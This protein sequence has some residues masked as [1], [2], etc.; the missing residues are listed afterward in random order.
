MTIVSVPTLTLPPPHAS[1]SSPALTALT[2]N[3]SGDKVGAVFGIRKTGNIRRIG[4]RFGTVTTPTDLDV[5][6][7]TISG[8]VPSGTLWG[9]NTN[10]TIASGSMASSTMVFAT[11][12]AD[13][14]VTKGQYIAISCVGSGSPNYQVSRASASVFI[15]QS[16]YLC[17]GTSGT[18][19]IANGKPLFAVE[20]DDGSYA[21]IIW[22]EPVSAINTHTYNTGSTPDE[23]A[24][25]FKIP[26][27][28][29]LSGMWV[30]L[31]LDNAADIVLYDSDGSTTLA[32]TSLT[33][34][35]RQSTTG[36]IPYFV[37]FSSSVTLTADT[38][39]YLSVK[40]TSGSSISIYS[41][42]VPSN[43]ALDQICSKNAYY[44]ARSDAGA[45]SDTDTR[46]PVMG[47]VIDGIDDGAGGSGGGGGHII[48]GG[49]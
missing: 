21:D 10:G 6:V 11:L 14:A 24:L 2:I 5:R 22:V 40:P 27:T 35:V 26:A 36:T 30:A 28:C 13:A 37:S 20:Y 46:W 29:R 7:E 4:V 42:D 3:A 16:N 34:D 18:Y 48:G 32:T 39:Y 38:F 1:S 25:K 12:T 49:F 33:S 47:L 8:Q 44:S 31:D 45:W 15:S 19:A 23:I 43:A 41:Y 17:D 9:T